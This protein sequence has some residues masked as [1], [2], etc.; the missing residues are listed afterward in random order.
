MI[1]LIAVMPDAKTKQAVGQCHHLRLSNRPA[2]KGRSIAAPAIALVVTNKA[3]IITYANNAMIKS[4]KRN[5]LTMYNTMK[6][7]MIIS[8]TLS[9]IGTY[10][11]ERLFYK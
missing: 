7:A 8:M 9:P 2:F 1:W 6:N 10:R 5:G 11:N 4:Q 3:L